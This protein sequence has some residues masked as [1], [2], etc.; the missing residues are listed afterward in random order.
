MSGEENIIPGT[1]PSTPEEDISDTEETPTVV[2][3]PA[4]T[5]APQPR[6]AHGRFIRCPPLPSVSPPP[7]VDTPPRVQTPPGITTA[8]G[9]SLSA[10]SFSYL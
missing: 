10:R 7:P 5:V 4:T 3:P 1:I 8:Q 6:D 9:I 2:P